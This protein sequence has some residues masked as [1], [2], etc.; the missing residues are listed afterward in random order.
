M[1]NKQI[2]S[3]AWAAYIMCVLGAIFYCYEYYLRVAP[4]VM[5]AE[6]M[7]AYNISNVGLGMLVAHYYFAYV[8]LQIPVGIMMDKWGPRKVL[9]F[10]CL[11]C[12]I[13][14]YFFAGTSIYWVAKVGRFM[15]GFGSAFAYVGVLK[16]ANLW[17]PRKYFAIMA[18]LCTTL[19]MVG[20]ISGEILMAR[21][22]E[23][24]GWRQSLYSSAF[25]GVVLSII[26]WIF[27]KDKSKKDKVIKTH[28]ESSKSSNLFT[29]LLEVIQNKQLW[30]NGFIGGLLFLPLTAFA[31][32]WAVS[33][34]K[35]AGLNLHNAA[36][37]SSLVFFGYGIGG[38]MWG[39]VS[40]YIKSRRIPLIIGSC[41]SSIISL[42]LIQ[43]TPTNLYW[44]Y[45]SLLLCG[46]FAS[47]QVLVFAVGNDICKPELS[48]T[49]LSFTNFL[50]MVCGML[51]QPLIGKLLDFKQAT[52]MNSN[53][54][55]QT[56]D[57][58][59]FALIAL[60]IGLALSAVL[61]V[62]LKES[63]TLH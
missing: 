6:L 60:P 12:S 14:T 15:V 2:H 48:A 59:R 25:I 38:P 1:Q 50:T 3:I 41:I 52:L 32:L 63:Y 34:L 21:F 4:S 35:S 61:S 56:L 42:Y 33:F 28:A 40:E 24:T 54:V 18:G 46:F 27:I 58:F 57:D 44:L 5:K 39:R 26:L 43:Y 23:F 62:I 8:P 9:T 31:E 55:V 45:L 16:I 49:V 36:W 13:G 10:A 11:L 20:A 47:A 17:L 22:V 30:I 37:G 7:H 51:A 19:G 29:E 53:Y